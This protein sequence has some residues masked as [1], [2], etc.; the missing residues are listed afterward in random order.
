MNSLPQRIFFNMKKLGHNLAKGAD[1]DGDD[2]DMRE[3]MQI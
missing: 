1:A 2:D 3:K